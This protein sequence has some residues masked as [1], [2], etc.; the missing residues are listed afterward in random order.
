MSL[1]LS[2]RGGRQGSEELAGLTKSPGWE[3]VEPG[4]ERGASGSKSWGFS[5]VA[6]RTPVLA[7]GSLATQSVWQSH[8]TSTSWELIRN[9]ES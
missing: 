9:A 4:F 5:G 3:V 2:Y 1:S 7:P 6:T 8:F